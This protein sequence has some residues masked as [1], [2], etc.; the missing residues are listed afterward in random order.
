MF[1]VDEDDVE[2]IDADLWSEGEGWLDEFDFESYRSDE[3]DR[4]AGLWNRYG[5]RTADD[6]IRVASSLALVQGLVD[7]FATGDLPYRVTFDKAVK[8]AG[9]DF[10]A[11]QVL[12][13][14]QPLFDRYITTE[15]AETVL[16]AMAAHEASHVRYGKG[17]AAAAAKLV[18]RRAPHISNILDDVRI[19]RRFAKDYPGFAGVFTPA[20]KYVAETGLREAGLDRYDLDRVSDP[21]TVIAAAIRYAEWTDW[22]GREVERDWWLA[23]ADRGTATDRVKDHVAAVE[24]AL[25]HLG[26]IV[27]P[28]TPPIGQ[29][30]PGAG[31]GGGQ[32]VDDPS[33]GEQPA[34]P[35][36]RMGLCIAEAIAAAASESTA[37]T[38]AQAQLLVETAKTLVVDPETG[39]KGEVYLSPAGIARKRH[40]IPSDGSISA[41]IRAAFQ[42]TRTGH[43]DSERNL[44]S[45]RLDNR[46]LPRVASSDLRLFAKRTA[47]SEDRYL[48]W[49]LVD[50]SGSMTGQPIEDAA[51]V[52]AGLAAASRSIPNIRLDVWGWTSGQRGIGAFSAT[53][54]WSTGET[55]A[56]V[57]YLPSIRKGG[58]P[59]AQM[60]GWAARAIKAQCRKGER[61]MIIIA[62]D[63]FGT[64]TNTEYDD[65]TG[66]ASYSPTSEVIDKARRSGVE[67]MSVAIG[68]IPAEAQ[69]A[70]YGPRGYI[71]W[72][73][74]I[75]LVARPLADMI[76]RATTRAAR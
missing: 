56:N 71:R 72:P 27:T 33:S 13:S 43:Y 67:V 26:P 21:T 19:E 40:S 76:A 23:W 34:T 42:R 54:V 11:R 35:S 30:V 5:T 39:T 75:R 61:P 6:A 55:L 25:A 20:I 62:S 28:P 22:T 74:S 60:L 70:V 2:V 64:L 59:D 9:T 44:R 8:T 46:S 1:K 24:E 7:T 66:E 65:T 3:G 16:T 17:T 14:H 57:G 10:K 36:D 12:I 69:E 49:L 53:R 47:P 4:V 52:A 31:D 48:V 29:P 15:E 38:S 58:T 63:G 50:C 51:A 18:D 73:G 41:A 45:G 37:L 32:V 68:M